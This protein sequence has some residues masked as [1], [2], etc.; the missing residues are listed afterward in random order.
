[1]PT[2]AAYN[3]FLDQKDS[4]MRDHAGRYVVISEYGKVLGIYANETDVV[5]NTMKHEEDSLIIHLDSNGIKEMQ[6]W[7]FSNFKQFIINLRD[8]ISGEGGAT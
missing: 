3:T 1:M 2:E 7:Q 4:L 6:L 8:S 5:P